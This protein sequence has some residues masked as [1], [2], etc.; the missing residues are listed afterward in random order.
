M[1]IM[2]R[3]IAF[4]SAFIALHFLWQNVAHCINLPSTA[5]RSTQSENVVPLPGIVNVTQFPFGSFASMLGS[6]AW[7]RNLAWPLA[8]ACRQSAIHFSDTSAAVMGGLGGMLDFTYALRQAEQLDYG[9]KCVRAKS[10]GAYLK[11]DEIVVMGAP[12]IAVHFKYDVDVYFLVHVKDVYLS[13]L[14]NP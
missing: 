8:T 13:R 7:A 4:K 6:V 5:S 9:L 1:G 3:I 2:R 12:H 10:G 11:I 14:G